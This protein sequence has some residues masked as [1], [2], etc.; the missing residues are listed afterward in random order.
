MFQQ[1]VATSTRKKYLAAARGYFEWAASCGLATAGCRIPAPSEFDLIFFVGSLAGRGLAPTTI[2]QK[3]SG[4]CWFFECAGFDNPG[5][6]SSGRTHRRLARVIRGVRRV[7]S[8]PKRIRKPIT[9]DLLRQMLRVFRVANPGLPEDDATAVE[10]AL[11][12]AVYGLL[13]ASEFVARY[14][15]GLD[16]VK[17]ARGRDVRLHRDS[18]GNVEYYSSMIRAAKADVFRRTTTSSTTTTGTEDCPASRMAAWLD[19][20]RAGLDEALFKLNSGRNLTRALL[21]E[22]MR[23]CLAALGLDPSD[24]APHSLRKGGAVSLSAAG[25]GSETICLIGRWNS[26][27]WKDYQEPSPALRAAALCRMARIG[28]GAISSRDLT[29]FENR[30]QDQMQPAL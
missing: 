20:R 14:A 17:D 11:C 10:A 6:D 21:S 28:P 27:S 24:F 5:R 30:F 15:T 18:L 7:L 16:E 23:R 19:V 22:T 13:R 4:I 12:H 29:V 26:D 1:G 3:I 2:E 8:R 9:T 25:Y